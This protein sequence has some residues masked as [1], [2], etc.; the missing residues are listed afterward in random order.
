M[1]FLAWKASAKP[2]GARHSMPRR[3]A[4]P[5]EPVLR[6]LGAEVGVEKLCLALH[7][8]PR[9]REVDVRLASVAIKFRDLVFED[10]VVAKGIPGQ[11]GYFAMILMRIVAPVG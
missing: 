2:P 5:I 9:G 4:R 3:R 8:L 6:A 1:S 7:Q 11:L 10:R